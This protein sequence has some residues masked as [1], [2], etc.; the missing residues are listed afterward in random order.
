MTLDEL[1]GYQIKRIL[2]VVVGVI[3]RPQNR[4]TEGA[5]ALDG[6]VASAGEQYLMAGRREAV[7]RMAFHAQS[8]GANAVLGMRFDH[9]VISSLWIE[10]CAYGTAV[11]ATPRRAVPSS[12]LARPARGGRGEPRPPEPSVPEAVVSE[13]VEPE[14]A[15]Y[16]ATMAEEAP[17]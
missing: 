3:A 14:P 7:Q 17:S 1:P 4:Y 13:V 16:E 2:G 10:I 15:M 6:D 12:R 9:R 8:Q 11:V 5:R